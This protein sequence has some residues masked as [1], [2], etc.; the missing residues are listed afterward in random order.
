MFPS[1]LLR[2]PRNAIQIAVFLVL[3]L[4]AVP[5]ALAVPDLYMKDT[6]ADTGVEPNPDS[7]PMYVSEDI[8]IKRDPISGYQPVPFMADPAWLT[9]AAPLHQNPEY[10]DPKG[11]RPNYVYVRIRNRGS[12]ASTG[13]ER[14]RVYW[15]KASTGLAW[16]NQF[17]DYVAAHCGVDKLYGLEITK[18]RRNVADLSVPQ[19]EVDRY[20]DAIVAVG[21]IASF[22]F[23]DGDSYWHK[24]QEVHAHAVNFPS[25]G[26]AAHVS[27]G[28]LPWHRE[29]LNRYEILLREAFPTVTLFYYD[30]HMNP[31][32]N[33]R[34]TGLMGSF[35]GSIG[36]PFNVLAPPTVSRFTGTHPFAPTPTSVSDAS[37]IGQATF[38]SHRTQNE[39][40]HNRTHPYLGGDVG[41]VSSP[42]TSAQDPIFFLLH[43]NADRLWAMW[44]RQNTSRFTPSTAY[45]GSMADVTSP[46]APWNGLRYN[47]SAPS[48]SNPSHTISP[49]T[50]ADGYILL[51]PANDP[52]VV[53]PPIYDT[54]LLTVP[55][56][57][58]G[59][60]V[61]IEIPWY[62]PNPA[63]F[64]CFGA[65]QGHCCLLARIETATT[66]PFGMTFLEG[67]DVGVNTRNNNNIVWKN[68]TVV[69]SFPGFL[70]LAPIWLHNIL[71]QNTVQIR[72]DLLVRPE[73]EDIFDFGDVLLD[74]G[75][76]LF[77][78]WEQNGAA[79]Q[80]FE[81]VG[82]TRLQMFGTNAFITGIPLFEDEVKRVEVQLRLAKNYPDPRGR[83]FGVELEQRGAPENPNQLIGGQR[84]VF[85][86]NKLRLV[87][88]R[89]DWRYLDTGVPPGQDW[90][91]YSFNDLSWSNGPAEL[92]YG[93]EDE[94]TTVESG[95]LGNHYITTWFRHKFDLEDPTAYR[96]M[97]LRLKRDDGAAVY[98]NGEEIYR[99]G[100]PSGTLTPQTPALDDEDGL[101]EDA[102]HPVN[103]SPFL[104]LLRSN[105]V[106][107]VEVHQY[108]KDDDDLGFDLELCANVGE[109]E[110][111]PLVKFLTPPDGSLHLQG[112]PIKLSAE[113]LD[114]D[115]TIQNVEYFYGG[116]SIG[117]ATSPTY[118]VTWNNAPAGTLML[119]AV[120]KDNSGLTG[121]ATIV[122][123]VRSNLPPIVTMANPPHESMY[124]E[125]EPIPVSADA[126]DHGGSIQRVDFYHKAHMASFNEPEVLIGTLTSAPWSVTL[127]NVPPEHYYLYA[128]ATDNDGTTS[129]A[130]P[131]MVEVVPGRPTVQ[132]TPQPPFLIL[133][134]MPHHATV[135][136]SPSVTGP[137]QV[138][139]NAMPPLQIVATN[140]ATFFRV[141]TQ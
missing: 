38:G 109:P 97:W 40:P 27:D 76:E 23:P 69:D 16:P 88:P 141:H 22:Q 101:A 81:R 39:N 1:A 5:A 126:M 123:E 15:A 21:T 93:D 112:D 87:A 135:E 67:M 133:D 14:L 99:S 74:L 110:A 49:W 64:S 137:W 41:N 75:P 25:S 37:V 136:M 80:G 30:W 127:S 72:L 100:L 103:V 56:L 3:F 46:M 89:A 28:F 111:P 47:G 70:M 53:F 134:W 10:R 43:G 71:L 13:T 52:S 50:T 82:G 118:D 132:I 113:A 90:R 32:T 121:N 44:Q 29:Y 63:D 117:Q 114:P 58:A 55:V 86:F 78:R 61:V 95:P 85:D 68:I 9:A 18:P 51:K 8:W 98:L 7:G 48:M 73:F 36:A 84:F 96:N 59:E 102:Y 45:S 125:G 35:S 107:A 124:F 17:V 31:A 6:P 116:Q 65:D 130:V 120:A 11:S 91:L 54:A 92:G 60:S 77:A 131:V 12:T 139:S 79:G 62:P 119:T 94:A 140:P 128:V 66:S 4:A 115:G 26:F 34:M 108:A 20:R 122:I 104:G 57:Q 33:A 2:C 129:V 42:S 19:A 24:Q 138:L 106:I 105:N 83:V